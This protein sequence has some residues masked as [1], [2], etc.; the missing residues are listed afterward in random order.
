MCLIIV[1]SS[2]TTHVLHVGVWCLCIA[3]SADWSVY[4]CYCLVITCTGRGVLI[5][6]GKSVFGYDLQK[7]QLCLVKHVMSYTCNAGRF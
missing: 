5:T 1:P 4:T 2:T 6:V 7:C 3:D